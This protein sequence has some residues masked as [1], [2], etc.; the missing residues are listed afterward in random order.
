MKKKLVMISP[1][2]LGAGSSRR[3]YNPAKNFKID[4]TLLLLKQDKY[5][6]SPEAE[7]IKFTMDK[8]NDKLYL[9]YLIKTLLLLR[10]EKPDIIHFMKP[11]HLTLIPALIY[12]KLF[13]KKLVFD[14]ED[15]EPEVLKALNRSPIEIFF[16]RKFMDIALKYSDLIV[17]TSN[18]MLSWIPGKF[19]KKVYFNPVGT[20][21]SKFKPLGRTKDNFFRITFVGNLYKLL[22]PLLIVDAMRLL[23]RD[24]PNIRCKIIGTGPQEK[25]FKD[26]VHE[27]GL[28]D[29]FEI[30]G[31][32]PHEKIPEQLSDADAFILPYPNKPSTQ[33]LGTKLFEYM[34]MQKPI[35]ATSVGKIP[36][37][38]EHG[39]AGMLIPD[40]P[41][42][43]ANA[44]K[45]VHDHP[46]EAAE[47][48]AYARQLA[49]EKYDWKVLSKK[50]EEKYNS[51]ICA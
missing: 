50:L 8:R 43:L 18:I 23:V 48:A 26:I 22:E 29:F 41:R 6:T 9:F 38:L 25:K 27:K 13:K 12:G 28:T 3:L 42:A 31:S 2:S 44:V 30:P 4:K 34:S 24:I 14:C 16:S 37:V 7:D 49:I 21:T 36:E 47:K 15:N 33:E 46:K 39:K 35:I 17:V 20:D 51:L 19:H 11:H 5:G 45:W 32:F 1:F 10:R 40:E